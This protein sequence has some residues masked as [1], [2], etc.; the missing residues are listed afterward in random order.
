[1]CVCVFTPHNSCTR[2]ADNVLHRADKRRARKLLYVECLRCRGVMQ[3]IVAVDAWKSI[4]A[5]ET[6]V[7]VE[8]W[9]TVVRLGHTLKI[10]LISR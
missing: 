5:H 10:I 2:N 9:Q 1:V 8:G 6:E 7:T 3:V 4:S